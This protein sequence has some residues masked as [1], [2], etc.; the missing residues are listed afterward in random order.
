MFLYEINVN[1]QEPPTTLVSE[2]Q[3]YN[4]RCLTLLPI[5][6][7]LPTYLLTV[8]AL[9]LASAVADSGLLKYNYT[10]RQNFLVQMLSNDP[11]WQ[12]PLV[13]CYSLHPSLC[14]SSS[15]SCTM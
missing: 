13:L 8:T 5:R 2:T 3:L 10:I 7:Y 4:Q 9:R 12:Q 6:P 11:R 15:F 14:S 1:Q